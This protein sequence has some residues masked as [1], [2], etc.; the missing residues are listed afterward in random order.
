MKKISTAAILVLLCLILAGPAIGEEMVK[1]GSGENTLVYTGIQ[2]F[3]N[4]E[5]ACSNDL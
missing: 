1:E 2:C 4:G 5:R 3:T